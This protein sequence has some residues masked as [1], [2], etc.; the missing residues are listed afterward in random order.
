M[1]ERDADWNARDGAGKV[2]A[3]TRPKLY[4]DGA[5]GNAQVTYHRKLDLHRV[6]MHLAVEGRKKLIKW[7]GKSMFVDMHANEALLANTTPR[8]MLEHLESTCAEPQH[9]RQHMAQVQKA[10]EAPLDPKRPVEEH[11]MQLQE[12]QDDAR[13]LRC[14]FADKK[15]MDKA[16]EQFAI[17]CGSEAQKAKA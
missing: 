13:L 17:K 14:P 5:D 7:F 11:H 16:L 12:C 6:C 1:V 3:P 4:E 9:C 8:A 2:I 10:F 15:T